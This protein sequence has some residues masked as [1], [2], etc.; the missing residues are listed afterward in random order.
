MIYSFLTD[1]K[2][3]FYTALVLAL[4]INA[5]H[6]A[7]GATLID[8]DTTS[9]SNDWGVVSSGTEKSGW[10]WEPTTDYIVCSADIR[11]KAVGL[12]SDNIQF[13]IY[14]N[15][16]ADLDASTL[17]ASSDLLAGATIITTGTGA[18][19]TLTF[20]P[21]V[22][23]QE[24]NTYSLIFNR[25]GSASDTDY[26]QFYFEN[27]GSA[28]NPYWVNLTN[29]NY[30]P[31]NTWLLHQNSKSAFKLYGTEGIINPIYPYDTE[32]TGTTPTFYGTFA[33]PTNSY[34]SIR[35]NLTYN[36]V[37]TSTG[38]TA[39][40]FPLGGIF[41]PSIGTYHYTPPSDV[42]GLL[43]FGLGSYSYSVQLGYFNGA[44]G[45]T[46]YSASSSIFDFEITG[47]STAT[48]TT[49]LPDIALDVPPAE[50]SFTS[51]TGCLIKTLTYLFVPDSN[52]IWAS[53]IQL[54]DSIKNKPPIGYLLTG[55]DLIDSFGT[56]T[57][58]TTLYLTDDEITALDPMISLL[59]GLGVMILWLIFLIWLAKRLTH[60]EL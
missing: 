30:A 59:R 9:A 53:Y 25:T 26:Y 43:G 17:I 2:K 44:T 6:F 29:D 10:Y 39:F 56:S 45:L 40:N 38:D 24:Q 50:C 4:L 31:P 34:N 35:I 33:D 20:D 49:G 23:I 52:S 41:E 47:L 22:L 1:K 54:F 28:Q 8:H 15:P 37:A 7:F 16:P 13:K 12:P 21:C 32:A 14:E 42:F 18:L 11:F 58:T 51:L 55:I 60:L 46:S 19:Y 5:Y 3:L 27:V 36:D 57:A 48:N